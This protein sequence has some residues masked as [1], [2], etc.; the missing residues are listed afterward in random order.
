MVEFATTGLGLIL[1]SVEDS[2]DGPANE[3]DGGFHPGVVVED[4]ALNE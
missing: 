1:N 3:I 2:G 4:L